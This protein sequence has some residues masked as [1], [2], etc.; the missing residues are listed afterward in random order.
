MSALT[1]LPLWAL[2][3]NVQAAIFLLLYTRHTRAMRP[4]PRE[5]SEDCGEGNPYLKI[6]M[7]RIVRLE[8]V[9]TKHDQELTRRRQ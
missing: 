9:I 1:E 4:V 3:L 7:G 2:L 6:I 5:G 8:K